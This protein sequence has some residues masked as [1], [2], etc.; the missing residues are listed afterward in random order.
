MPAVHIHAVVFKYIRG[1][2]VWYEGTIRLE[3]VDGLRQ[4]EFTFSAME[5]QNG[6]LHYNFPDHNV[7]LCWLMEHAPKRAWGIV[8]FLLPFSRQLIEA[9]HGCSD[10]SNASNEWSCD[11]GSDEDIA[12]LN[13]AL[14][15]IPVEHR[16]P[17]IAEA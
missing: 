5:Q 17:V 15:C 3:E 4:P 13:D 6:A 2:L 10:S 8:N 14:N 1:P 12:T 9:L 11:A 16:A 7:A